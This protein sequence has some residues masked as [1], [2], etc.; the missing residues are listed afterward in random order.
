MNGE[1][2]KRKEKWIAVDDDLIRQAIM[3]SP[4][5]AVSL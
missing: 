2:Q 5:W 1:I 4:T 3:P